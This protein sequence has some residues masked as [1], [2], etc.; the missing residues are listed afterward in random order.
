MV[1]QKTH[2]TLLTLDMRIVGALAAEEADHHLVEQMLSGMRWR[3]LLLV[4]V[5]QNVFIHIVL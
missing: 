2:L 5:V 4:M 1:Q 3:K